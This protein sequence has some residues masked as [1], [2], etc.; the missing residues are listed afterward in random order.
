MYATFF[1]WRIRAGQIGTFRS[2]WAE[3]TDRLKEEGSLGSTLFAGPEDSWCAL[4]RWP[5]RGV[6]DAAFAAV[7]GHDC[8]VRLRASIE[9]T[10]QRVDLDLVDDRSVVA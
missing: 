1:Q 3:V 6:R 7:A 8:A 5:S 4:A 10:L 2:A 9:E